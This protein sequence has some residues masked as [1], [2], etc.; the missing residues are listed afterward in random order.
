L[1]AANDDGEKKKKKKG[2]KR[3]RR[4]RA[5]KAAQGTNPPRTATSRMSSPLLWLPG[6]ALLVLLVLLVL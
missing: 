6:M 5:V 4:I 1:A 2:P 3:R